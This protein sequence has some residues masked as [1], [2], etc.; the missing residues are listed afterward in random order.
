MVRSCTCQKHP[1]DFDKQLCMETTSLDNQGPRKV[2]P[3]Y[4]KKKLK[5]IHLNFI[6]NCV[7]KCPLKKN[8]FREHL[9]CIYKCDQIHITM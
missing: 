6:S 3:V 5:G 1:G 7:S 8:Y 2:S 4:Q 9:V